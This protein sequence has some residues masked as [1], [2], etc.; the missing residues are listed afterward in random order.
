MAEWITAISTMVMAI[1]YIISL[2]WMMTHQD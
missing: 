2:V 1:A